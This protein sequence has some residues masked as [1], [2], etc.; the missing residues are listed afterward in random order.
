MGRMASID[1]SQT[2]TVPLGGVSVGIKIATAFL[3]H[4]DLSHRVET[5]RTPNPS[6][7]ENLVFLLGFACLSF[8]F[9]PCWSLLVSAG[10]LPPSA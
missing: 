7:E 5:F 6:V 1:L 4:H 3:M 10:A 2:T 9:S 8:F